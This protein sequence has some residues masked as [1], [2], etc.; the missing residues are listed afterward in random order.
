MQKFTSIKSTFVISICALLFFAVNANGQGSGCGL[1]PCEIP[2]GTADNVTHFCTD[3]GKTYPAGTVSDD[4]SY[5]IGTPLPGT[6]DPVFGL[7]CLDGNGIYY[8]GSLRYVPTWF[9]FRV[10]EITVPKLNDTGSRSYCYPD[11]EPCADISFEIEHLGDAPCTPPLGIT[12]GDVDFIGWGPFEGNSKKEVL[13]KIYNG[14]PET[15]RPPTESGLC[16]S[17][18]SIKET[19]TI[20][21]AKKGEWY[22]LLVTNF[23]Q[24]PG[25]ISFRKVGG[26]AEIACPVPTGIG[27]DP[28]PVCQDA[29][30]FSLRPVFAEGEEP[31]PDK[32]KYEWEAPFALTEAQK[33]AEVLTL[34]REDAPSGTL[35]DYAGMYYLTMTYETNAPKTYPRN[36]TIS[37]TYMNPEEIKDSVKEKDLPYKFE[38]EE[39]TTTGIHTVVLKTVEKDGKT[40]GCDS[41]R[42]LDLTVLKTQYGTGDSTICASELPFVHEGVTFT[43]AG[44][45]EIPLT[46]SNGAD[47]ILTF[48]LHVIDAKPA[49]TV[50]TPTQSL[51][52]EGEEVELKATKSPHE[53]TIEWF[54]SNN[55]SLGTTESIMVTPLF[56]GGDHSYSSENTYTVSV[57]FCGL[58]AEGQAKVYVDKPLAGKITGDSLLCKGGTTLNASSYGATTYSWTIDG[59]PGE[60]GNTATLS[61]TPGNTT[62]YIVAMTRGECSVKDTFTVGVNTPPLILDIDSIGYL[63][64]KII[65]DVDFGTPPFRY[66]V[67]SEL[68]D[69]P[70]KFNLQLGPHTFFI[71][72]ALGCRSNDFK[73]IVKARQPIFP[74]FFSPNGDGVNDTWEIGNL[75]EYYPNAIVEIFDRSGRLV[76]KYMGLDTGWDGKSN[77]DPMPST[78]YWYSVDE[79]GLDRV[80]V[81][82]FT[83][84]RR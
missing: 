14:L 33:K 3:D 84:R 38:G 68:G 57:S 52:G 62:T 70:E 63:D 74:S 5:F 2:W 73:H 78:D 65:V 55:T 49:V 36:V 29:D 26:G 56:T 46:A 72:D 19:C 41:L 34:K 54:D 21:N 22:L 50:L 1:L 15:L 23:S 61:V 7:G 76:A 60:Q 69:Y 47:S 71:I 45:K 31:E 6:P 30:E 12:A 8:A 28:E 27:M 13:D 77:G 32:M 39:F 83:L 64:R 9:I 58:K 81:G 53:A 44:P 40:G 43:A 51:C 59:T 67:D 37:P 79:E 75:R 66:G 4:L 80:F 10:G 17:S 16:Q 42:I 20:K 11:P 25:T 24:C 35:L 48:T 82:H 18:P